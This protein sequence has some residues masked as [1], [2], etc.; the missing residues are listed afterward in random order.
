MRR[1]LTALVGRRCP[2]GEGHVFCASPFRA[3]G[4]GDVITTETTILTLN[5]AHNGGE[6]TG[7]AKVAGNR[8]FT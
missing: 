7:R 5:F 4:K 6:P 1:P 2:E 3:R 8:I